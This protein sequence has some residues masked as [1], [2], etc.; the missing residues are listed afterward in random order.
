MRVLKKRKW[1]IIMP[2][3]AFGLTV[4]CLVSRLPNTY[5][6][7]ALLAVKAPKIS[8]K[9][10]APLSDEDMSQRLHTL[11][12][13]I[14]SRSNLEQLITK[15]SLYQRERSAGQSIESAVETMRKNIT[16][17]LESDKEK[18]LGFRISYTGQTPESARQVTNAL[19]DIYVSKQ[20]DESV[21]TAE[22][23]GEFIDKQLEQA[24]Q[25]LD[26]IEQQ[27]MKIMLENSEALPE[28]AQGLI[29]QLDGLRKREENISKDKETL[30]TEKLRLND[31]IA[32]NNRQ[33]RLIEDYGIKETQDA[34]R[35]AGQIEDTP[36][37]AQ[38]VNK[39]AE[40][41]AQLDKLL[42]VF[43]EKHPDVV[44]K[45]DE[46]ARVNEELEDLRKSTDKRV[47]IASQSSSRKAELQKKSLDLENQRIQSQIG[48]IDQ[49]LQFNEQEMQQNAGRISAVEEKIN[50][51][52]DIK[53]ALESVTARY[54]SAKGVYDELLKKYNNSQ[55]Q[56]L[57]ETDSQG[58]TIQIVDRANLPASSTNTARKIFLA[59]GG[60]GFGIGLGMVL[61]ACFEVP[62]LFRVQ[63]VQ[64]MKHYTGLTAIFLV[65]PM[66]TDAE[67]VRQRRIGRLKWATA[68][69]VAI[70]SVPLLITLF[71]KLHI[72]ERLI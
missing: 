56:I 19:A 29:A 21:R 57:R 43:K 70:G 14:L 46:I 25:N 47:Q 34:A 48:Q 53:I 44:A 8:E 27:R 3:L 9:I 15:F 28:S 62:R 12:Q 6:S 33:M 24:K 42:K 41:T 11:N 71:Q 10:V 69:V 61:A 60:L 64:D 7:T 30:S 58:E 72:F 40:L 65:P 18:L 16:V 38:L 17:D 54:E 23:T 49:Q 13:N 26:T 31:Q 39:R 55:G 66:L 37:Y 50:K 36:A 52:P 63:T 4:G 2:A 5:K 22:T 45:R 68:F 67:L 32:S 59:L 35:Q 1:Y 51:I 20:I